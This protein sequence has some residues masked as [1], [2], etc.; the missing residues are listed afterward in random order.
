MSLLKKIQESN[1]A[2]LDLMQKHPMLTGV[3]GSILLDK[4]LDHATKPYI[5][6]GKKQGYEEASAEY[7]KKLLKQAEEFLKQKKIFQ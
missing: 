4:V 3:Y 5:Y 6:E 1:K 7:E 2:G